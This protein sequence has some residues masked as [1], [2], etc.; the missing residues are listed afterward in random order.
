MQDIVKVMTVFSQQAALNHHLSK[1]NGIATQTEIVAVHTPQ[2]EAAKVFP[3]Q[4]QTT[5]PSSLPLPVSQRKRDSSVSSQNSNTQTSQQHSVQVQKDASNPELKE[6]ADTLVD[7]VIK[8]V[9]ETKPD[10][11]IEGKNDTVA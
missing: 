11:D 9:A 6:F 5:R 2:G 4:K 1:E 8:T 3:F 10:G 7:D